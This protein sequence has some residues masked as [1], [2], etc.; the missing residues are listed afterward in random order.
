MMTMNTSVRLTMFAIVGSQIL[1]ASTFSF[2]TIPSDGI[3]SGSP[4]ST[5]D[6]GYIIENPDPNLYLMTTNFTAGTFD[7]ATVSSLF[8]FPVLAPG[9]TLTVPFDPMSQA[10]LFEI[11]LDLNAPNGVVDSGA[12]VISAD[13]YNGDPSS[14]GGTFVNSAD[15]QI[16]GYTVIVTPEPSYTAAT[17][18]VLLAL[19]ALAR[20]RVLA[21]GTQDATPEYPSPRLPKFPSAAHPGLETSPSAACDRSRASAA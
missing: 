2:Q 3:L 12:F 1:T 13:F 7:H 15:D 18:I 19:F 10:G 4:G 5:L 11:Q 14:G 21:A 20:A 9:Q 8:D 6:Y 17:A 16:Q